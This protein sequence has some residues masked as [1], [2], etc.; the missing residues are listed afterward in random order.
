MRSLPMIALVLACCGTA[1]TAES[2]L[3]PDERRCAR[4]LPKLASGDRLPQPKG[5]IAS[6]EN[7]LLYKAVE[8]QVGGCSVLVMHQTGQLRRVPEVDE[9]RSLFVPAR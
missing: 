1:A 7:P 5:S 8:H 3:D 4:A 9:R 2:P 6:A